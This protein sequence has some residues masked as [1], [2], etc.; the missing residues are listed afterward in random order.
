M[1]SLISTRAIGGAI[2]L[3]VAL[4]LNTCWIAGMSEGAPIATGIA[5]GSSTDAGP[6]ILAQYNPC[7]NRR[8][9]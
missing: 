9:R 2:V 5:P 7:P 3:V 6:I 8:C 1:K 4:V